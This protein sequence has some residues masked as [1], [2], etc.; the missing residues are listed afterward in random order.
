[1]AQLDRRYLM[2]IREIEGV[3]GPFQCLGSAKFM[4]LKL[5]GAVD[6]SKTLS[7]FVHSP[8]AKAN[9]D[10]NP[11]NCW[12]W[13]IDVYTPEFNRSVLPAACNEPSAGVR[14]AGTGSWQIAFRYGQGHAE[15][16]DS[17]LNK[18]VPL[19]VGVKFQ[20]LPGRGHF[21]TMVK[22]YMDTI[23]A[24]DPWNRDGNKPYVITLP[25][26]FSFAKARRVDM[27][28]ASR[29]PCAVPWFGHYHDSDL[30]GRYAYPLA[31]DL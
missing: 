21:I 16:G 15:V 18:H 4:A 1:M 29:I 8:W 6:P 23:W 30:E 28:G 26:D 24:I 27:A 2:K 14:N 31:Q 10:K 5:V 11:V 13:S 22:D 25:S 7:D 12:G 20:D 19:V 3:T 9:A 17:L